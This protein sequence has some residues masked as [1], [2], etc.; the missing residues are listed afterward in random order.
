MKDSQLQIRVS[1]TQKD[2]IRRAAEREKKDISSWVLER[3]ISPAQGAF[4][5]VIERLAQTSEGEISF[6][7]AELNDYLSKLSKD[8]FNVA[9]ELLPG[10]QL[11]SELANRLAAMVESAAFT[12]HLKAPAWTKEIAR[13][14]RPIFDSSL[15]SLRLHLLINTPAAFKARDVFV[16]STVGGRV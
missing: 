9:L 1:Q 2:M 4:S 16:D 12:K 15:V 7:L 8:E 14:K 6:V 13:L 10:V 3:C 11:N 5:I